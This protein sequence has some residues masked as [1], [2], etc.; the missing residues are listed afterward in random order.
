[1]LISGD[2][3]GTVKLWDL[4][5]KDSIFAWKDNEDFIADIAVNEDTNTALA[6]GYKNSKKELLTFL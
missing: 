6:A 5:K 1:M 3:D 4:R 2:D